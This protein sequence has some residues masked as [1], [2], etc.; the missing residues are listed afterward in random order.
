MPGT[1]L[2]IGFAASVGRQ[3]L[4]ERETNQPQSWSPASK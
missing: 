2:E 3:L 4:A 1:I